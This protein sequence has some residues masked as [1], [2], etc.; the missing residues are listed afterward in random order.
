MASIN[1]VQLIGNVGHVEVRT[2]EGGEKICNATLATSE[3]Y[4]NRAGEVVTST[5]WHNLVIGG[6]LANVADQMLTKGALIYVEG[7]LTPRKYQDRNGNDRLVVE[8][9][10]YNL[11]ILSAKP[12]GDKVG[13]AKPTQ[14]IP[15]APE[16]ENEAEGID[17]LPF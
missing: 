15:E 4:K 7:K 12:A 1:K 6:A 11:Q 14:A 9:R 17:D 8:V 3:R 16:L 13:A 10:V 5:Y 2:F